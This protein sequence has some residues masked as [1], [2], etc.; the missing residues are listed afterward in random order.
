MEWTNQVNQIVFFS[1]TS[2]EFE[3]IVLHSYYK[4]DTIV[5]TVVKILLIDRY[6]VYS[7]I[8]KVSKR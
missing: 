7:D 4:E 6:D 8:K 2:S 5:K 1:L 3:V